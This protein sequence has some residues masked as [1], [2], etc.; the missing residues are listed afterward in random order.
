RDF[1]VTAVQTCALP[2]CRGRRGRSWHA[3]FGSAI[4]ASFAYPFQNTPA[5]FGG[6]GLV[7]GVAVLDALAAFGYTQLQL[8][9]PND[10]VADGAKLGGL[11]VES[12]SETGGSTRVVAGIGL[13]WRIPSDA[14][15]VVDQRWTDLAALPV[16]LPARDD[17][18]AALLNALMAAFDEFAHKGFAPFR[19][20]WRAADALA[21]KSV[22]IALEQT[23]VEGK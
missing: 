11:L 12:R 6:V 4:C 16:A 23:V 18:V 7:A 10:V 17:V 9:W 14:L 19:P 20:R 21:G 5:G 13:N 8:K 22:R 1:H 15:A 3:P 2:I